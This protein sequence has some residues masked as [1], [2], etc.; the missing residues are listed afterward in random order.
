MEETAF[1]HTVS[2][3][4]EPSRAKIVWN[5]LDGRAYTASELALAA[6]LSTTAVSNHLAKLLQGNIIKVA[7]QGRHRY[8]TFAN[9]EVAYAVE[10]LANLA[11]QKQ[12]L[13]INKEISKEDVKYCRTCYDHL[14]GKVGVLLTDKMVALELLTLQG[15]H[16]ILTEKGTAFF[17]DFGLPLAELKKQKRQFAKACLDWSERK[18]HISGSLGASILNKMLAQDWLRKTKNSRHVV[19]T[20][21]GKK[22]LKDSFGID[23]F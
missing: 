23:L 11:N 14:A 15:N 18:Y 12:P 1:I 21:L 13:K 7:I 2:L 5:L 22:G 4:C 3:L 20:S 10:S 8:Y 9:S 6:D 19:I 16:F 17:N